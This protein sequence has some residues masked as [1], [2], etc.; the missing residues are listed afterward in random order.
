M[1]GKGAL[2]QNLT[3]GNHFRV[4]EHIGQLNVSFDPVND[5]ECVGNDR[6]G[7]PCRQRPCSRWMFA[8]RCDVCHRISSWLRESLAIAG[9]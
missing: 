7:N 4:I 1:A 6:D 2:H 8:G 5:R 3:L 9:S